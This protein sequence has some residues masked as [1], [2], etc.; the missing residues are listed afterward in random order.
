MP[1]DDES[2]SSPQAEE[3]S[4]ESLLSE[5]NKEYLPSQLYEDITLFHDMDGEPIHPRRDSGYFNPEEV[6]KFLADLREAAPYGYDA[7]KQ[8]ADYYGIDMQKDWGIKSPSQVIGLDQIPDPD[9][10]VDWSD[11]QGYEQLA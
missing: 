2:G 7:V 5:N 9:D 11:V 6:E 3:V 10:S 4:G 8:V 1:T